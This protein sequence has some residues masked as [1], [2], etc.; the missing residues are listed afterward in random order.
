MVP[1]IIIFKDIMQKIEIVNE[2][3]N[4]SAQIV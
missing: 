4:V 3:A 1:L 2:D